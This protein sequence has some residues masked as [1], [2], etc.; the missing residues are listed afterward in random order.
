MSAPLSRPARIILLVLAVAFVANNL[1]TIGWYGAASM[2]WIGTMTELPQWTSARVPS[3]LNNL[4]TNGSPRSTI[5][6][7]ASDDIVAK[8][9]GSVLTGRPLLFLGS[10][11]GPYDFAAA[12]NIGDAWATLLGNAAVRKAMIEEIRQHNID[13]YRRASISGDSWSG[14]PFFDEFTFD[15]R[16][17][18]A[19]LNPSRTLLLKSFNQNLFNGWTKPGQS[20]DEVLLT[21]YNAVNN[22][23]IYVPSQR[24]DY[25]EIPQTMMIWRFEQDVFDRARNMEAIGRYLLFNIVNPAR[26]IRLE[27]D[28]TSTLQ[29][30]G[31]NEIPPA[32]IV[33]A[34]RVR[35]SVVGHGAARLF[36]PP[37]EP[38]RIGGLSFIELDMGRDGKRFPDRRRGL[39][40][41]YGNSYVFDYRKLVGF[42]RD[43]SVIPDDAYKSLRAPQ[44]L[45]D[46]PKDLEDPNL[47]FS[48]LY[49]DGWM[50]DHAKVWLSAP[51]ASNSVF[52]IRAIVPSQSAERK[53]RLR[54]AIDGRQLSFD[55]PQVGQLVLR[56]PVAGDGRRHEV[57]VQAT[58]LFHLP[59]GDGRPASIL[60]QF[61]G[62]EG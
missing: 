25:N 11:M 58:Q 52:T 5:I 4:R 28:F 39:M 7:D 6:S 40:R 9:E 21:P 36:S 16:L 27:L 62:Y 41:L 24:A 19:V 33:G 14:R 38:Q 34:K 54:L 31:K 43:I 44:A 12:Y 51:K 61:L 17:Q 42:I 53:V 50:A 37:V 48:G 22:F 8:F 15:P 26:K 56:I 55:Q 30:D 18:D 59:N 45:S 47:E 46:F 10:Y 32:S 1:A 60:L 23:L 35:F 13:Y 3:Q 57:D 29:A 20:S 2:D 49:E